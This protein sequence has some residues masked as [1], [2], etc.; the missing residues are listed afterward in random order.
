MEHCTCPNCQGE[1]P[2]TRKVTE[3]RQNGTV[4]T[5]YNGTPEQE[6]AQLKEAREKALA[7]LPEADQFILITV[8][9]KGF[10]ATCLVGGE[11]RFKFLVAMG[12]IARTI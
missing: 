10:D 9:K 3:E 11:H 6:A 7:L 4:E 12:D 1:A 2:K 5:I 8:G